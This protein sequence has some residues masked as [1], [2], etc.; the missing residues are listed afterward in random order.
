MYGAKA[1]SAPCVTLL[2]N[3]SAD[4]EITDREFGTT[5]FLIACEHGCASSVSALAAAGAN[6][7]AVDTD[8]TIL[9]L[10]MLL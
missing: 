9:D 2:A 3:A 1:N 10:L 4:L 8:G 7:L 6:V 5:A